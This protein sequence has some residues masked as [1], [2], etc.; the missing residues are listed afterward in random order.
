MRRII[1]CLVIV[2]A[3]CILSVSCKRGSDNESK[4]S[5]TYETS[6]CLITEDAYWIDRERELKLINERTD[7]FESQLF[8]N[9]TKYH[10][11]DTEYEFDVYLN[12]NPYDY[13]FDDR[14]KEFKMIQLFD[15]YGWKENKSN[16]FDIGFG[17]SSGE[18]NTGRSFTYEYNDMTVVIT[19]QYC[20]TQ[21]NEKTL[22][23]FKYSFIKTD[24]PDQEYYAYIDRFPAPSNSVVCDMGATQK[25]EYL[26]DKDN[27]VYTSEDICILLSYVIS[28][29]DVKPEANPFIYT[30]VHFYN[31][32]EEIKRLL[33][34]DEITLLNLDGR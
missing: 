27:N 6:E 1:N 10:I 33:Q 12:F 24:D 26:I 2:L 7:K 34:Y 29:V 20:E 31:N 25:S 19:L 3:V 5:V 4:I 32:E 16:N 21:S 30:N 8:E 18:S 17:K 14:I 15:E 22:S 13:L 23:S 28:W 11:Q 9:K